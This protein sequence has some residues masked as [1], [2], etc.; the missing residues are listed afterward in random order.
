MLLVRGLAQG[1]TSE[2]LRFLEQSPLGE[3]LD[4]FTADMKASGNG[5]LNLELDIPLRHAQDTKMRGDYRFQNNQLQPLAGLPPL[6]QVNGRLLLTESTATAQDIVGRAFG[7]PLK[8]QVRSAGDKV[9]IQASGTAQIKEVSN[10][11]GW[12]LINH[13]SGSAGWKA[14]I[15][16]R[17]R[18]AEVVVESDLVGI[19]S[20]LPEPLN[21]TAASALPLRIEQTVPEAQRE[22]Y[23]IVLGKVGQGVIVRRLGNWERGVFA[24]GDGEP[25]L[26]DRGLAIRVATPRIDADAW[27]NYLPEG[28]NGGADAGGLALNVVSLKTPLLRVFERDFSNVDLTLRPRDSGW[29]IGLNTREAV[30]DIF[31][32]S[33]G[34]GWVEGNFKRLVVRPA[35]EIGEGSTTL[36]NTLPGMSLSV[37]D[38]HIG[39]KALGKLELRARN[40]KGRGT[41]IRSICRIRMLC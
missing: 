2:F 31:W 4:H 6:N 37:D 38:L 25:R 39:D 13:L 21:K 9:G 29:Q 1:P 35:A 12:P 10:H 24:V 5:S 33:A 15:A 18:T 41:S 17:K 23:R 28:S 27:K 30:G 20:P 14:D 8:V 19:T 26:P 32:K 7:G 40:D 36:I 3:K 22:Q 16:I 11:F 34:E